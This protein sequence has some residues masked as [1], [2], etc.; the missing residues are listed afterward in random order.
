MISDML[1]NGKNVE[2]YWESGPNEMYQGQWANYVA[3]MTQYRTGVHVGVLNAKVANNKIKITGSL[4]AENVNVVIQDQ[5][6][7][8][9]SEWRIAIQ[10]DLG[11][12]E[13]LLNS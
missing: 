7:G 3:H 12:G 10:S 4:A 8:N 6:V 2:A 1:A 11:N 9:A 5:D 13:I